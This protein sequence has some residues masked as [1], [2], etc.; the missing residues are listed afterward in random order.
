[1][2]SFRRAALVNRGDPRALDTWPVPLPKV[3]V[4][5]GDCRVC[6]GEEPGGLRLQEGGVVSGNGP[7]ASQVAEIEFRIE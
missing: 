2:G 5:V 7:L 6:L 1:M 4:S 3:R